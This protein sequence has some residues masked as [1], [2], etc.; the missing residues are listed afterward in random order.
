M[1]SLSSNH[2]VLESEQAYAEVTPGPLHLETLAARVAAPAAGA[3]AT[4]TGTTRDRWT[5]LAWA[6]GWLESVIDD[7]NCSIWASK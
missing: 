4:F 6:A 1:L 7:V 3:V 5:W 2:A